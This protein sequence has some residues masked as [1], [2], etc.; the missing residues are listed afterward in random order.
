MMLFFQ[1]SVEN[2]VTRLN[3]CPAG[4]HLTHYDAYINL[5]SYILIDLRVHE[6]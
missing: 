1:Q 3:S 4:L 6:R 2:I 5:S